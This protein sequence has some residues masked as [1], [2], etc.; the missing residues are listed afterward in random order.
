MSQEQMGTPV[1]VSSQELS[2]GGQE[3]PIASELVGIFAFVVTRAMYWQLCY[4]K[5]NI[6]VMQ[7]SL[8]ACA[9]MRQM[10]S[11]LPEHLHVTSCAHLYV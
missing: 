1:L 2:L 8:C 11:N 6:S 9:R 3:A 4:S 10:G 5:Y 7:I